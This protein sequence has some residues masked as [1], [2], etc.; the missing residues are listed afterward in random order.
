MYNLKLEITGTTLA[1]IYDAV[2]SFT[3]L[4]PD[5][6][7]LPISINITTESIGITFTVVK[8]TETDND[9]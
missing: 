4:I 2:E 7:K 3:D 5:S 8:E 9:N 1:D 6:T